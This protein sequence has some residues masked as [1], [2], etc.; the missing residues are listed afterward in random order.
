MKRNCYFSD[1]FSLKIHKAYTQA[2]C[3]LECKIERLRNMMYQHNGTDGRCVPW[4]YPV[5]DQFVYEIC[6]P[7]Q[8]KRFQTLL[9]E[10]SHQDCKE[11][12]P[13]CRITRYK[14]SVSSA[15]FRNCDQTTLGVSPLCDLSSGGSLMMN[16][17]SFGQMIHDEYEIYNNGTLPNFIKDQKGQLSNI[18]KYVSSDEDVRNLVFRAQREKKLE[19]N[20]FEEDIAIVNFYFDDS[21]IMQYN[22]FQTM[23]WFDYISQVS[24]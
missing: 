20:A 5:E 18:R 7:W 16:P 14:A 3:V 21:T 17:P 12:L 2:N 6:D 23:T 24:K 9:K 1:E 11:C 15:P 4:F 13:D 8:T 19:Y 22:T 10:V